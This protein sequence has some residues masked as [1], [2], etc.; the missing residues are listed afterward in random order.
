MYRTRMPA[1][2]EQLT[3]EGNRPAVQAYSHYIG[4]LFNSTDEPDRHQLRHHDNDSG[5]QIRDNY[6]SGVI[7]ELATPD[8]TCQNPAHR[9]RRWPDRLV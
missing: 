1:F 9:R 7:S 8:R 4:C 2:T 5:G 3:P 6:L